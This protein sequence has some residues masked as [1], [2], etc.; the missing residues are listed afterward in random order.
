LQAKDLTWSPDG[1]S[2]AILCTD[3]RIEILTAPIPKEEPPSG[4]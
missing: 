3:G 4:E 2:L 1:K